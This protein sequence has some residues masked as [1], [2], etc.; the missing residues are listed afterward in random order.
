MFRIYFLGIAG[1]ADDD[2]PYATLTYANG[3]GYRKEIDGSRYD[4]TNDNMSK[5]ICT[6]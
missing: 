3:P 2:L 5:Y 6:V 1:T 4:I